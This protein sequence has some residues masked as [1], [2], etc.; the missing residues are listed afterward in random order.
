MTMAELKQLIE[1]GAARVLKERE[2][3]GSGLDQKIEKARREMV[4]S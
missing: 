3:R 1:A 2:E 4:C